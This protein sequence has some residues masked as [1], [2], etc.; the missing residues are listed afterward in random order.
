MDISIVTPFY[1][2]NR[3]MERL[4][5]CIRLNA[6]NVPAIGI[7]LIL[8]N[9]SP[10]T[11]IYY[12][13]KWVDGYEVHILSNE[14]NVGIHRSRSRGIQAARG[15]YVILL[16]QDDLLEENAVKT[17][18]ESIKDSDVVV[19]NGFDQNPLN[20]GIIYHSV[21]HQK[22]VLDRRFYFPIGNMIISPGQC[23]I[24]KS[25]FPK[26]WLERGIKNNGSDDLLLWLLM[27]P[28]KCKWNINITSIYTHVDT[29]ENV[30]ANFQKMYESSVEVLNWLISS[31]SVTEHEKKLFE[32]RFRMRR[33]YEGKNKCWK[34]MACI[35]FP[36]IAMELFK[37]KIR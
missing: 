1:K 25:A 6:Q 14:T 11:D 31:N 35:A 36:D 33:M 5:R 7:E 34:V 24:K 23:M 13:P 18:Y 20:Y 12:N 32:R 21:E 9:D 29:K 3:Y 17:Q 2:G 4:F 30:S 26:E 8:V 27:L 16:D 19:A 22:M 15:R 28:P 10:D 37:M